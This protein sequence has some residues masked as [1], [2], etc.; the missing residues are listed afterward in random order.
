MLVTDLST[1]TYTGL[2]TNGVLNFYEGTYTV[3]DIQS[4]SPPPVAFAMTY[5]SETAISSVDVWQCNNTLATGNAAQLNVGKILAAAFNRGV[6]SDA[7]DD[8]NCEDNASGF[9]P[10]GGVFNSWA[11]LFHEVS[12]NGLAY[13]F[14]YDDV[15]NQNPTVVLASTTGV[16]IALGNFYS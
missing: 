11:Q 12:S 10:S 15:C 5:G 13:G 14:P 3:A 4:D 16:T 9:Y 2:V 8:T 1:G 6:T 7:M